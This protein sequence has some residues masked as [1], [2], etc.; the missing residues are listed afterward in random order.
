MQS[1]SV[2][3]T[4]R[5]DI[6]P[7]GRPGRAAYGGLFLI[8]LSCLMY[9]MLLTRIFSATLWYHFA[10]MV[11]SFAMFG[12]TFGALLVYL[13]PDKFPLAE[14]KKGLADNSIRLSISMIL[15]FLVYLVVPVFPFVLNLPVVASASALALALVYVL[16]TI[17]FIF[18]GVT[19]CLALT[20][21]PNDI[22]RLYAAD[23]I[24]GALG[25]LA[26][27]ATLS[28]VDA[29]TAVIISSAV[30][31]AGGWLFSLEQES[32]KLRKTAL[33]A[34]IVIS[35]AAILQGSLFAAGKPSLHLVWY[36]GVT[37]GE[38]LY[39]RWN[40]FSYVCVFPFPRKSGDPQTASGDV[41][42]VIDQAE[43]DPDRMFLLIDATAGSTIMRRASRPEL[44]A[45]MDLEVSHVVHGIK[46]NADVLIIGAGGGKDVLAALRNGQKS[47]TAIDINDT[48][49]NVLNHVFG[50]FTGHL[51]QLPNVRFF[52]DE[53][54]SFISRSKAKFDIIQATL[55]DTWAA[56]TAGAFT[57]TENS[58]YTVEA[59]RTYLDHLHDGGFVSFTRNYGPRWTAN[60]IY[61]ITAL[62]CRAL[63]DNGVT[64]P[65]RH[66]LVMAKI[67]AG[68]MPGAQLA[69]I[70]VGKSPLTAE[71]MRTVQMLAKERGYD[72]LLTPESAAVPF[73]AELARPDNQ[74]AIDAYEYDVSPPTDDRPF[75]FNMVRLKDALNLQLWSHSWM[76]G[77]N[78][79]A[80]SILFVLLVVIS[81]LT[82]LCIILPL[83]L[84][85]G[86]VA[87]K[88]AT[89]MIAYF[90]LIGV[91]F[92][93]AEVSLMQ[94]LAIFL[95]HPVYSVAVVLSTLL[96]ASGAGSYLTGSISES[97]LAKQGIARLSLV[98]VAMI[99][100][101]A[102]YAWSMSQLIGVEIVP[103]IL[104]SMAG[105]LAMGIFM[106]MAFPI[107]IKAAN[108]LGI[109]HLTPWFWGINGATSVLASVLAVAIA[110]TL[111][112]H[113]AFISAMMVYAAA[114][115]SFAATVRTAE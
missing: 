98:V 104:I 74:A 58:L 106:G 57:L 109:E 26:L 18:A 112:I 61:R 50:D 89:P 75:F 113:A 19:T 17:P 14:T 2:E 45:E 25:C 20:R 33:A 91:G 107:G 88:G 94:R 87:F 54:R 105:L 99:F 60:E 27:L 28:A 16:F 63:K 40:P 6:S 12:I 69:T 114:A 59:W 49:L 22:S 30:A 92:M 78:N 56:T 68:G 100:A 1:E 39:E 8:S 103:R 95:G 5:L 62:A 44:Y 111:G 77:P 36:K 97:N 64:E 73:L 10:F 3:A 70:I 55:I 23:L 79:T 53:A 48:V 93:L 71:Q 102:L 115:L 42:R 32:P 67:Q 7:S 86:A 35:A 51:D 13:K 31:A 43:R 38:K 82:L 84:K 21:F 52:R 66:I 41:K 47:I 29:P 90:A 101:D 81:L 11:V 85:A 96:V 76:G 110:L 4:S 24:G 46:K 80:V 108:R 34:C 72:L 83:K 15:S 37:F 65:R 9:E